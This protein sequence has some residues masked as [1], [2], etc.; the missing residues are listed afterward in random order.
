MEEY[1]TI[2]KYIYIDKESKMK[3]VIFARED[4]TANKML[5]IANECNDIEWKPYRSLFTKHKTLIEV[6]IPPYELEQEQL[7]CL[8]KELEHRKEFFKRTK[9]KEMIN[10]SIK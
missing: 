5:N 8:S 1:Y 3:M 6:P 2:Y 9:I 10:L 4:E 7:E